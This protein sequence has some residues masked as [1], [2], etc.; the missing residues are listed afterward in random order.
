MSHKGVPSTSSVMIR[1]KTHFW[2]SM[3]TLRALYFGNVLFSCF[4]ALQIG[5]LYNFSLGMLMHS[6]HIHS[7]PPVIGARSSSLR[8]NRWYNRTS[9]SS[10]LGIQESHW[11]VRHTMLA[12]SSDSDVSNS[13]TSQQVAISKR[14]RA[15]CLFMPF[16]LWHLSWFFDCF[17]SIWHSYTDH[18]N[19]KP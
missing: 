19:S 3:F 8:S 12:S 16:Q 14:Q 6:W 7:K 5:S 1:S 18:T 9:A 10:I 15:S 13:D 11:L 2:A 17:L 4:A